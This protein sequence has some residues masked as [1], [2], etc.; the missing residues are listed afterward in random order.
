MIRA[1]SGRCTGLL[2]DLAHTPKRTIETL[3][4]N[5]LT[6]IHPNT[7]HISY[8]RGTHLLPLAARLKSWCMA[9]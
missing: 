5:G 4:H 8:G 6:F 2:S 7:P 1:G 3:R 9:E